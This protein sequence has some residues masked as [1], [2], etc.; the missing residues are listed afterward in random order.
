MRALD[1]RRQHLESYHLLLFIPTIWRSSQ[2]AHTT[3]GA[4]GAEWQ[5]TTRTA[6][7]L[8]RDAGG[9]LNDIDD[10]RSSAP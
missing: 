3:R 9:E 4:A 10:A 6:Q 5:R 7:V 8:G 2:W 1:A